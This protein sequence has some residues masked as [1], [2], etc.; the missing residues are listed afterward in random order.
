MDGRMKTLKMIGAQTKTF[1]R[2]VMQREWTIF[3]RTY[4]LMTFKDVQAY[5]TVVE[6]VGLWQTI[7]KEAVQKAVGTTTPT[8]RY[9]EKH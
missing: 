6:S 2:L 7:D 9:Q 3:G 1:R 4:V 8:I 5:A